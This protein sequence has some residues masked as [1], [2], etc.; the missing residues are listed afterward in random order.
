[1]TSL[2]M[3]LANSPYKMN[4]VKIGVSSNVKKRMSQ[5]QTN[6]PYKLSLIAE[7]K[8]NDAFGH[9]RA[10]H[11]QYKKYR[12]EGEWFLLPGITVFGLSCDFDSIDG[13][14]VNVR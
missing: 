9:E 7:A 2:Y 1:M 10:L 14:D 12:L 5:I 8:T 4:L 11:D 3:V 6:C 13:D